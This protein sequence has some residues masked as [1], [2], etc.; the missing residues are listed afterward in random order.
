MGDV[1]ISTST[2]N[3]EMLTFLWLPLPGPARAGDVCAYHT[4]R[5]PNREVAAASSRTVLAAAMA[6]AGR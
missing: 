1:V 4:A 6:S 3:G 2:P 5:R